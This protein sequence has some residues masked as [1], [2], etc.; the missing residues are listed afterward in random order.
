MSTREIYLVRHGIPDFPDGKIII[1]GKY[2]DLD[3]HPLCF[4]DASNLKQFFSDKNIDYWYCSPLKR[5]KQTLLQFLPSGAAHIILKD[6]IEVCYGRWEGKSW[7]ESAAMDPELF[8]M[9]EKDN[10]ILPPDGED[11]RKAALRMFNAVKSA[12]G[13]CVIATH[14]TV[15]S[16]LYCLLADFPYEEYRKIPHPY[17]G[18]SKIIE[19]NGVYSFEYV[20][21]KVCNTPF[22]DTI[23]NY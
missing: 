12:K 2:T 23:H 21:N 17:L 7:E 8:A 5:A 9:R 22:C 19:N 10:T 6:A 14:W 11:M 20:G 16:L 1:Q 18:V 13:N 4:P 3:L 15:I